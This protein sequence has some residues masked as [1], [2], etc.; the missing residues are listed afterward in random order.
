MDNTVKTLSI[1]GL[2]GFAKCQELKLAEP[3]GQKPGVV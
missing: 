3:T 1:E 2:R